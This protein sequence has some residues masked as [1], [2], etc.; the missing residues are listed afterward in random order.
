LLRVAV[1]N[2]RLT[3]T[4]LF[5]LIYLYLNDMYEDK[6]TAL[7]T[8]QFIIT[9]ALLQRNVTIDCFLPNGVHQPGEMSLLLINDGQNMEELAL[10]SMLEKL[11]TNNEIEPI[12]CVAIHTGKE[13]KMEYGTANQPDYKGWGAKAWAYT[14]FIF[15]ELLPFIRK[16]YLLPSFKEKS[17]AGFSLGGL[18]ALDIVWNHPQEFSKVGVFSASLWWRT[19]SLEEDYHEDTDRIMHAQVRN[20]GYYPWLKF[21]FETGTLD[22]TMDRNNNGIIDSIDDTLGLI[23][24]LVAKGYNRQKDIEYLELPD[25]RHDIAT[26]ARAMPSFLK[27]GWGKKTR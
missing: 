13:R 25:G 24:E 16:T 22:E 23:N 9:S 5:L 17:F 21:F 2:M 3:I 15:D 11:I 26:W 1:L 27:W 8:E 14:Q 10:G 7:L 6:T 12:V 18:S 4:R 19:K 20:G